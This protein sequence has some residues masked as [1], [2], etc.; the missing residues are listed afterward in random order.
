M[1]LTEGCSVS[2]REARQRG[3]AFVDVLVQHVVTVALGTGFVPDELLA[4]VR[5]TASFAELTEPEWQWVLD[6]AG[7]GGESLQAYPEYRRIAPAADGVYRVPDAQ[8]ARRQRYRN[9]TFQ[10]SGRNER[11]PALGDNDGSPKQGFAQ[12]GDRRC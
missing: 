5:D 8:V 3:A 11:R 7:R 9:K 4:E 6:F 12:G 1:Q 2:L 10:R